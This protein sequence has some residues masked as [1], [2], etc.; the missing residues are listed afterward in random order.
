[1]GEAAQLVGVSTDTLRRWV[2][3]GRLEARRDERNRRLITDEEVERLRGARNRGTVGGPLSARNRL[4][5]RIASIDVDGVMAQV[6]ID[7]GSHQLTAVITRDAVEELKLCEGQA[8]FA[9]IQATNVM[10]E[11][12]PGRVAV[13]VRR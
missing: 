9:R 12:D 13:R 1:M 7:A 11:L 3:T 5:G 6:E 8:V 2:A 4:A 10:V